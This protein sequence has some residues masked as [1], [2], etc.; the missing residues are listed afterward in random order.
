MKLVTRL[1][2]FFLLLICVPVFSQETDS[3]VYRIFDLIYNQQ[4]DAAETMLKAQQGKSNQFYLN[5]LNIDLYWWKYSIFRTKTDARNLVEVMDHFNQAKT[6]TVEYKIN[7]LIESSYRLRYEIKRY[8]LLEAVLLRSKVRGEMEELKKEKLP[9]NKSE[10]RL[11]QLYQ[12][13][14]QYFDIALN[15][16]F[17]SNKQ[18]NRQKILAALEKFTRDQNPI[19]STMAHYFLGRIYMKME[20][21]REKGRE[22]FSYLAQKYP[23]N[24]FFAEQLK[25]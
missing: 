12:T 9:L 20:R 17:I 3:V 8:N 23:L 2:I 19:I 6:E 15:P 4:S 25:N 11:F 22:Y 10:L 24:Q 13:L 21:N 1:S 16:F 18:E 5:I 7:N 14:F